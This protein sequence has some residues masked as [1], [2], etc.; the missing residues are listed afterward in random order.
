MRTTDTHARQRPDMNAAFASRYVTIV[1]S[2]RIHNKYAFEVLHTTAELF[3]FCRPSAI[4]PY[5]LVSVRIFIQ[6]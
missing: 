4:L 2:Q 6:H 1:A 5:S 3:S